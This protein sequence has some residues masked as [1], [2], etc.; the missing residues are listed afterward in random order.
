LGTEERGEA[1]I[2]NG[3]HEGKPISYGEKKKEKV[4]RPWGKVEILQTEEVIGRGKKK[5]SKKARL[6]VKEVTS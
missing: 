2:V 3:T 6:F 1:F 5:C 4:E